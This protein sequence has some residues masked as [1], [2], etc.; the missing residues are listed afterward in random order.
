MSTRFCASCGFKVDSSM[1]ICPNCNAQVN[2]MVAEQPKATA[3]PSEAYI[4]PNLNV[5]QPQAIVNRPKHDNG[6]LDGFSLAVAFGMTLAVYT[7]WCIIANMDINVFGIEAMSAFASI[8]QAYRFVGS[9][10]LGIQA[11]SIA[12]F[13]N[14]A[15]K[16]AR[17]LVKNFV[18][19]FVSLFFV[20]ISYFLTS[21][22]CNIS[23]PASILRFRTVPL[24]ACTVVFPLLMCAFASIGYGRGP[25]KCVL[26]QIA[27][28]V[29]FFILA[30]FMN[31][32]FNASRYGLW[33]IMISSSIALGFVWL[34]G[35]FTGRDF[36]KRKM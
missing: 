24:I 14:A 22:I 6:I 16:N 15:L 17:P 36:L 35:F 3:M 25:V 5:N 19:I 13:R 31:I 21:W 7:F 26:L 29:G 8:E 10:L 1:Q 20:L 23:I 33:G 34:I 18:G 27:L 4:S 32:A 12:V 30:L 2:R 28:G 9:I 11:L